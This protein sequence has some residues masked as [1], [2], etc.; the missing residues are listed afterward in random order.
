MNPVIAIEQNVKLMNNLFTALM[1]SFAVQLAHSGELLPYASIAPDAEL[2]L[3]KA[4]T[5]PVTASIYSTVVINPTP[6][7][8]EP[9]EIY[10][11]IKDATGSWW[12]HTG[13][14]SM[15]IVQFIGTSHLLVTISSPAATATAVLNLEDKSL[16]LIGSGTGELL[17][18]NPDDPLIQLKGRKGYANGAYWFQ[19]ISDLQGRVIEFESV[20]DNCM[21]ISEILLSSKDDISRLRQPLDHCVGIAQ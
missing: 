7:L 9:A 19:S 11:E 4:I 3:R 18:S 16:F 17:L 15:D 1:I 10:L 5:G 8:F 6:N 20:G 12:V 2:A 21:P 13:Y 14:D